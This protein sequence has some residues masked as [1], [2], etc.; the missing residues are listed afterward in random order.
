[1][2]YDIGIYVKVAGCGKRVMIDEPEHANPTY[3]LRKMFVACMDW[4]YEQW[5]DWLDDECSR[6]YYRCDFA[7]KKIEHGIKELSEN[8]K[9]YEKYNPPNGW[10]DLDGALAVLK[11][12]KECICKWTDE[13]PLSCLYMAW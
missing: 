13:I 4:D 3:N 7:L 8:R 2:S 6:I 11:S 5:R 12:L 10:G 1:M 9:E